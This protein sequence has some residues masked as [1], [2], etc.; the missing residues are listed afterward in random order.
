[1]KAC[2]CDNAGQLA[3]GIWQSIAAITPRELP[4]W[5][6]AVAVDITHSELSIGKGSGNITPS[7]RVVCWQLA[8]ESGHS[9]LSGGSRRLQL[10][11]AAGDATSD[12]C[13]EPLSLD[14]RFNPSL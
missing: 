13:P 14:S 1:M 5:S 2:L 4:R 11:I 6:L 3:G 7:E 8:V 9:E 12:S 10:L